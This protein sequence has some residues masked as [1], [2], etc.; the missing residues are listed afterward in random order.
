MV[1]AWCDNWNFSLMKSSIHSLSLYQI[2]LHRYKVQ[3]IESNSPPPPLNRDDLDQSWRRQL[4]HYTAV[5]SRS[6]IYLIYCRD[7][8][9]MWL[10]SWSTLHRPTSNNSRISIGAAVIILP[11]RSWAYR[12]VITHHGVYKGICTYTSVLNRGSMSRCWDQIEIESDILC[13]HSY[14]CYRI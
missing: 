1:S 8:I 14:I 6:K 3:H 2:A 7:P 9:A 12:F 4:T 5:S 10:K 11:H 13:W